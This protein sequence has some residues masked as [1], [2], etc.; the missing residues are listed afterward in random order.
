MCA[1]ILKSIKLNAIMPSIVFLKV[2]LLS[3]LRLYAKCCGAIFFSFFLLFWEFKNFFLRKKTQWF[4]YDWLIAWLEF[5]VFVAWLRLA[6]QLFLLWKDIFFKKMNLKVENVSTISSKPIRIV[7]FRFFI[8]RLTNC[9]NFCGNKHV[10]WQHYK[11]NHSCNSY[12]L[13]SMLVF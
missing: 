1:V 7:F 9:W 3:I 5:K 12:T 2:I 13:C 4:V 8:L 11:A 6:L 10:G